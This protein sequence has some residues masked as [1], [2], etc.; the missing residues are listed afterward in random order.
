LT[1]TT[2]DAHG[3]TLKDLALAQAIDDCRVAS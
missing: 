1:L 3:L 2:H